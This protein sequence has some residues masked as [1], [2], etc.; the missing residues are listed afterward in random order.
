MEGINDVRMIDLPSVSDA[1]GVLTSIESGTDTPFELKRIFYMHHIVA[2]RG[3]HA[4][5]DTDQVIVAACGRFRVDLSDGSAAQTYVLDDAQQGLY[6]PRM[7]FIK[8]SNFSGGAV[9]MVL[10]STHY[11]I[12][13][14]IR[15]WD[16]YLRFIG[17]KGTG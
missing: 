11:D 5:V 14:S 7:I 12:K 15:T 4:H 10:A 1:R 8:L 3:G 2:D 6:V 13:K 16:D 17:T 9:C